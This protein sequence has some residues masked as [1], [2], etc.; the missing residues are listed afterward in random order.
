M[1][2]RKLSFEERQ[3]IYL[4]YGLGNK[5][6]E[7]SRQVSRSASTI[8]REL[9]RNQIKKHTEK[10]YYQYASESDQ[11]FKERRKRASSRMRLKNKT[12]RHYV[13]FH[14]RVAQWS[15]EIIAGRLLN[16]GYSISYEAIYQ[17]IN[18]E[19][20]DLK[21]YLKVGGRSRRRRK[22]AKKRGLKIPTAPKKSIETLPKESRLREE[23]G[24]FEVDAI[25]GVKGG[26]V[27]QNITDR[28]SRRVFLTKVSGLKSEAYSQI[29][30]KR[31]AILPVTVR[32]T[33]L[34]DNGSEN[35]NHLAIDQLLKVSSYF[36][37]PY[38]SYEKGSVENRNREVRRFIAKST[39]LEFIDNDWIEYIEDVINHTP[40]KV[41]GFK[42]PMEV[43]NENAKLAA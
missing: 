39:D 28:K 13:E 26:E 32:K 17:W 10:S 38:C 41:L 1:K 16:C 23:I 14:L 3:K 33:L 30:I 31:L 25:E 27:I 2:R 6:R 4:L 15:P 24:H 19:R 36:C 18:L 29:V 9:K 22:G 8:S 40:M 5:I 35:S 37:H 7:I 21:E 20:A 34:L 12:I 11:S 42:T 43:W